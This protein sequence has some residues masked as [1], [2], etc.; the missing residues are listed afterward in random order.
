MEAPRILV[1]EDEESVRKLIV[2]V[3]R[4]DGHEVDETEDGLRALWLFSQRPYDLIITDL[5]MPTM[6]GQAFYREV[7]KLRPDAV[8]RIIFVTGE[9]HTVGYDQFFRDIGAV[10]LEKPFAVNDLQEVVGWA[11]GTPSA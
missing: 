11:L 8:P 10:A 6:D 2:D 5:R 9:A 3:L 1:I 7:E 4:G